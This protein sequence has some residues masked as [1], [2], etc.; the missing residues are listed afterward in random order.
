MS[1]KQF[2]R[3]LSRCFRDTTND[4]IAKVLALELLLIEKGVIGPD[5]YE[6]ALARAKEVVRQECRAYEEQERQRDQD[7][8]AKMIEA[9]K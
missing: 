5:E 7:R 2:A 8:F 1:N 4:C 3:D 9:L 6:P